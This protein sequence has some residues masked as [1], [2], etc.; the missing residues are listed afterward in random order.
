MEKKTLWQRSEDYA[1]KVSGE[2]IE[3]IKK[4]TAPWQKP[5]KPGESFMPQNFSTGKPYSG[6]NAL[7]LMSRGIRDGRADNRWGTYNQI[8]E[9][10]GQVRKGEKGTQV[11]FLQGQDGPRRERRDTARSVK[12]SNG[13]TVY[14]EQQRAFPVCKQYTV[15]NVEQADGLR[16]P[17]AR[18][19]GTPANGT[20]IET[21]RRS[22]RRQVRRCSTFPEIERTTASART[23]SCFRSRRSSRPGMGTTRRRCTSADT[24]PAIRSA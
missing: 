21:P 6:G 19:P 15:F 17:A 1:K 24:L 8:T 22:S 7:Y 5:W 20:R 13:K 9:A 10:G 23:R 12:D 2:I 14:D 16:A 11:L 3:Q 4:G 18:G